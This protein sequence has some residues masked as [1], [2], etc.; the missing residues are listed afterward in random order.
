MGGDH[1]GPTQ[2]LNSERRTRLTVRRSEIV[3]ALAA[4]GV[5]PNSPEGM[6]AQV[7][8]AALLGARDAWLHAHNRK[9]P[10]PNQLERDRADHRPRNS[11]GGR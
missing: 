3:S 9:L 11:F 5:A 4:A 6:N 2:A 1:S 8:G 10:H 7:W